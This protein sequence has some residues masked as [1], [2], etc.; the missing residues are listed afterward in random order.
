MHPRYLGMHIA[1]DSLTLNFE[2]LVEFFFCVPTC[3]HT[4]IPMSVRT[5]RKEITL[6]LSISV[7]SPTVIIDT[8]IERFSRVL[9]HGN[10]KNRFT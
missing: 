2:L 5:P 10:A 8:S 3:F 6:A 1:T 9:Q 7:I 4:R